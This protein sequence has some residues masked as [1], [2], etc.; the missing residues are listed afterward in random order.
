MREINHLRQLKWAK[1]GNAGSTARPPLLIRFRTV[2]KK[3]LFFK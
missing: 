3:I 1:A 2:L